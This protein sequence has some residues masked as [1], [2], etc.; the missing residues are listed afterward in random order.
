MRIDSADAFGAIKNVDKILV[1]SF[2]GDS[3]YSVILTTQ[4]FSNTESTT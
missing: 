1:R 2:N 3:I 4:D